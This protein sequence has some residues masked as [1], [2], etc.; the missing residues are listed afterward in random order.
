M[1]GLKEITNKSVTICWKPVPGAE[2]YRL[3][4]SDRNQAQAQFS[5]IKDIKS[6]DKLEYTL[7]KSTHI[8]YYFRLYPVFGG[9]EEIEYIFYQTPVHCFFKEQ[10]EK[11]DRGLIAVKVEPG[12][13][14]SWRMLLNEVWGYDENK[15]G[16]TG[17][18]FSIYRNEEKIAVVT[19]STNY[20]DK[21]GNLHD[22]YSVASVV[23]GV[24]KE[25]S[26]GAAVWKKP[27]FDIP[28]EKPEGGVTP[29][30]EKYTYSANDLS[31]ADVDG[32][33]AYEFILKWEPS[34]SH[35]V[36]IKGYT[37]NCY[38]D[39]YKMDGRRL[40]RLD[41][42]ANIRAGAHYTQFICYDFIGD[43]SAQINVK[44]APGTRMTRYG[45][46]GEILSSKYITIGNEDLK[47]GVTHQSCY[48]SS[49]D[50]YNR[51]LTELFCGWREHPEVRN[52]R[53]PDTLE[54]CFGIPVKYQYPLSIQDAKELAD[55]FIDIYAPARNSANDLRRFEGFIYQGP[56]YLTMF[57]GDG[58]EL[59]TIPF[60]F[61]RE[62]DGLL[63]G[64]Y[65]MERIEPCNRSDRFLSGVA[66]LDG[67]H[68]FL[69]VC[70]GYYTRTCLAAYRF[71]KNRFEE[72]WNIDSGF[73]PMSNPF[74]DTPH[75]RDG[76]DP[77]YG[78]MTGQGN[79][80]ISAADIDGDGCMEIIYG[81][82]CIDEDGSILYNSKGEMQDKTLTKLGHGDAMHVADID[83]DKPGKEIFQVFEGGSSVPYGWALRN[84]EDGKVIFGESAEDDP[85][86]C[87]TGKIALET[88]GMQCWADQTVYDCKGN[89]L[90]LKAPGT[91][92]SIRWAG[93]LTTQVTDGADYLNQKAVG[94]IYDSCRGIMLEPEDTLTNNGTKGNPCIVADI[95]G[96]FREEII[97]RTT[98]S[99]AIR[100][101]TNTEVCDHKLFTKMQDVQYRCGI[102]GQNSGYNQPAY[103]KYYYGSDMNFSN[104]LP[105]INR[106][107]ILYLA[108]DSTMQAYQEG[109]RP[110]TGWGESLLKF[111][112]KSEV[113]RTYHREDCPFSQQMCYEGRR[114]IVDNC[115]KSG[116]SSKTF[117][118]EE[119]LNDIERNIREGDF[120]LIQFGHND[121][122]EKMPIRHVPMEQFER[123]ITPFIEV[124]KKV[125]ATP[126]LV[127]SVAI[128]PE[129]VESNHDVG[130]I[131]RTLKKYALEMERIAEQ[132]D[133]V[134]VD[135]GGLIRSRF[136]KMTKK[137]LKS[138]FMQDGVHLSGEGADLAAE[139]F[140]VWFWEYLMERKK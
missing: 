97:L 70:R 94:A 23:C 30:G 19:D 41:L 71:V 109:S 16:M 77:V 136:D 88:R 98:D 66:Y 58:T 10:M 104:V 42:G 6:G 105:F 72:Y 93:D 67:E 84:A 111:L 117:L 100:I 53:W 51:H 101:Y 36:S 112:E 2:G 124:A 47:K 20:L 115:A 103:T 55:Y 78:C 8:P 46:N 106:K 102:A 11:L 108:G 89:V 134:Y 48:V 130:T 54:A 128:H 27:Y 69:I 123:Y 4:W 122:S 82:V 87:M 52:K 45:K 28:V 125:K 49:A 79:H 121:A 24:E 119:R 5:F 65:A 33:G 37:G 21:D 26:K 76:S 91:N 96:D 56:E 3:Y 127:S 59:D 133:C 15:K 116:R 80:S 18:D 90:D 68:P 9:K 63:W 38:I 99:N 83:P 12:V 95:F 14:L 118:M 44:T 57:S 107:P 34:N 135:L 17:A 85:G 32:D 13:F 39:C 40:W 1:I 129:K 126:I 64:D 138:L 7:K 131:E 110:Q 29:A 114:F 92:M 22:I 120:L 25:R 113:Y 132:K 35:D 73:V 137:R 61:L 140:C 81:A 139:V 43:G 74:C 50:D 86:R 75:L 62:D 31:V 60:P